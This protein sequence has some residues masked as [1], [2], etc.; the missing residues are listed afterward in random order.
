MKE[1]DG[2]WCLEEVEDNLKPYVGRE[3]IYKEHFVMHVRL[4]SAGVEDG[5]VS[6]H[7]EVLAGP[8][9]SDGCSMPEIGVATQLDNS[10]FDRW[11]WVEPNVPWKF[12]FDPA[13][14]A[15]VRRIAD[16][17]PPG[18]KPRDLLRTLHKELFNWRPPEDVERDAHGGVASPEFVLEDILARSQEGA[19]GAA[20]DG[21]EQAEFQ[22][23]IGHKASSLV[24]TGIAEYQ[25]SDALGMPSSKWGA[26]ELDGVRSACEQIVEGRG[27]CADRP[28][29]GLDV[30]A[31]HALIATMHFKLESQSAR[32]EKR[33]FLDTLICRHVMDPGRRGTLF[34]RV[35]RPDDD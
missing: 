34:V 11:V 15:R 9:G 1:T 2:A 26:H 12:Y 24:H 8:W 6:I 29:E 30:S 23:Y 25:A 16:G 17:S 22:A 33:S 18:D 10:Y 27:F 21:A 28:I 5:V 14:V 35:P 19:Q 20:E 4:L 3:A 7:A 31:T 13:L 32:V